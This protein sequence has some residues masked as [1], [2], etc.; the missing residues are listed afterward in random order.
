MLFIYCLY[1]ATLCAQTVSVIIL[2]A[3]GDFPIQADVAS[4]LLF[5]WTLVTNAVYSV[6]C[7]QYL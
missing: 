7:L 1:S 6:L 4:D 3:A 5:Q 2:S